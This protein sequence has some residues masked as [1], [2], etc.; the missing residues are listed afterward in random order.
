MKNIVFDYGNVLVKWEPE[1]VFGDYFGSDAE[2][3][4]FMRH[5]CTPEWRLRIDCGESQEL[6]IAELKSRFPDYAE[7]LELYRSRWA[8]M[9]TGEVPG[10][11]SLLDDLTARRDIEVYGL[12]NWSM[13]TFPIARQRFG[14]LQKIDRYVVSGDVHLV[15]PDPAIFRLL[16]DRFGLDPAETVFVDDNADNVAAANAVGLHGIQF[17][18]AERLR[19]ELQTL[20]NTTI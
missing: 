7:A 2:V 5:V 16:L 12:T 13:E 1:R 4:S 19:T 3:W 20:F 10:M 8:D 18:S 11:S 14:I 17:S 9:L 6:C 15:K